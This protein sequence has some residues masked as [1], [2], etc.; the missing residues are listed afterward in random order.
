M[1]SS[2]VSQ[3]EIMTQ[4]SAKYDAAGNSGVINILTKKNKKAGFNANVSLNYTQGVYPKSLNSLVLNFRSSKIN[5]FGNLSY[6]YNQTFTDRK[7]LHYFAG[8]SLNTLFTQTNRD[9]RVTSNIAVSGGLDYNISSGTTIGLL[10][11]TE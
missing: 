3:I 2:Q 10:A 6:N 9:K 8:D 4:P 7:W 11:S 1:P 5:V